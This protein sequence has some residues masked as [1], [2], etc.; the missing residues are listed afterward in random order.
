MI[1]KVQVDKPDFDNL[2]T[3]LFIQNNLLFLMRFI[4]IKKKFRD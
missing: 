1:Y 4:S 2:Y 3:R